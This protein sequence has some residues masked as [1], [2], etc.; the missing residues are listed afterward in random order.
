MY[1]LPINKP[2][3]ALIK[4]FVQTSEAYV[5]RLHSV[6]PAMI[7]SFREAILRTKNNICWTHNAGRL[8]LER[9]IALVI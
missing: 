1:Y 6:P 8:V 2:L 4:G 7:P 3:G 9:V 5:S